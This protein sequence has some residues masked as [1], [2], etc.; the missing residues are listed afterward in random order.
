M[1]KPLFQRPSGTAVPEARNSLSGNPGSPAIV[2]PSLDD[3]EIGDRVIAESMDLS[4]Y[5]RFLGPTEFKTGI[6]AGIELDT[7]SGKN[8]GTVLE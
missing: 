8:D 7:P 5:L 1:N 2:P 4:G 3:Y 6:W